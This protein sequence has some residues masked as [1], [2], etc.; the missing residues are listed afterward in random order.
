MQQYSNNAARKS[1]SPIE[2]HN[3]NKC[4][5]ATVSQQAAALQQYISNIATATQHNSTKAPLQ[6]KRATS[7]TQQ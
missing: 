5:N 7:Y 6:H 1:P 4:S 2:Q 3:N